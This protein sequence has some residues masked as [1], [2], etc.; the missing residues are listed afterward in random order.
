MVHVAESRALRTFA[1]LACAAIAIILLRGLARVS[2]GSA[3]HVTVAGRDVALWKPAGLPGAEGYPVILF[4]HGFTGCNTQSVFL[5]QA[6]ARAG[7]LVVAP[8]HK[9]AACGTA[10][11]PGKLLSERPQEPFV[12]ASQWSDATYKDREADIESVLDAV[13]HEPSFQGV[14]ID[15]KRVGIAGHSLG[16][17]TAIGVAGGW[18]SW[19]D[20]RIK[21]VLA[22]SPHCSPFLLKGD[23]AH[24][25]LPVMY[26]G[27][28]VDLGETPVVNRAGGVYDRSSAPKYF[29]EFEGAG[30]LAWTDLN[31]R[32]QDVIDAYS[33][34]F[35]D[36]YLKA[37]SSDTLA[38]LMEDPPKGVSAVKVDL[39]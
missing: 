27:G 15:P 12:D 20:S 17:Y 19:K 31:K 39:K 7:Y 5:M 35:F 34:A 6:L 18:P 37:Q 26:Q 25:N 8:N 36:Q 11:R 10:W 3:V 29:V 13:L 16:G 9:D 23:L 38:R 2:A 28:T 24:L 14:R 30:H 4:S 33:V 32:Y 1:L 21:A 22:F